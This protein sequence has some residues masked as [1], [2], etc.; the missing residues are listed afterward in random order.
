MKGLDT[1]VDDY[2][3]KIDDKHDSFSGVA[4]QNDLYEQLYN[5]LGH[6]SYTKILKVFEYYCLFGKSYSNYTMES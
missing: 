3:T 6:D 5:C 1:L 2:L 4:E